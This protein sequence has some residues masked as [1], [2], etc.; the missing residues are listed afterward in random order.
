MS[1]PSRIRVAVTLLLLLFANGKAFSRS[2]PSVVLLLSQARKDS[3]AP[4]A[5]R[6]SKSSSLTRPRDPIVFV[7][8][9]SSAE[10][11]NELIAPRWV[12][13]LNASTKWLV[14]AAATW[15]IWSRRTSYHGPFI[16]LG[17]IA[18]VYL[19]DIL[20]RIVNHNRPPGSPLNDPG[21][22]SSHSLVSFFMASAWVITGVWLPA[23]A[24]TT[25]TTTTTTCTWKALLLLTGA[26]TVAWL[27]VLTGY[28]SIDQIAVGAVLGCLLGVSWAK[29]GIWVFQSFPNTCLGLSWGLYAMASVFFMVKNMTAWVLHEKHL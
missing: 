25:T 23:C 14:T 10:A 5:P 2:R 4:L 24:A 7:Q 22:P 20:K 9:S 28:H 26:S 17:A 6:P 12:Y 8:Q 27:R 3:V 16:V 13:R 1:M 29:V 18:S 15:G 21:M 11:V 19:T